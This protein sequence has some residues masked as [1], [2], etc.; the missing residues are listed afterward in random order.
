MERVLKSYI[1]N[2][3]VV[4]LDFDDD[5]LAWEL[6]CSSYPVSFYC[7]EYH[8]VCFITCVVEAEN[9][10][11]AML[12]VLSQLP[13]PILIESV[14]SD[15]KNVEGLAIEFNLPVSEMKT[16]T[17]REGFPRIVNVATSMSSFWEWGDVYEWVQR[18]GVEFQQRISMDDK[19]LTSSEIV[20]ANIIVWKH[21]GHY[22]L[23]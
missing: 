23:I 3:R 8:G 2:V 19:P 5:E 20:R 22:G 15:F 4:G 11:E 18:E 10:E 13:E 7:A 16:L 14:V 17:A 6:E 12:L 9:V 21:Y 1:F